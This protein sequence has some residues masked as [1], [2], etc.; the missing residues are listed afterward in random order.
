M[1][2]FGKQ[3][4]EI[5]DE[6]LMSLVAKKDKRAFEV[7]Y[8]RYSRSMVNYFYRMLWQ[9]EEKAQDFMQ[10]LFMK[11]VNKPH[12]Y[13]SK[14]AFKTWLYSI[15]NNMCKNEYRKQEIRKVTSYEVKGDVQ[16]SSD[17]HTIR[18]ID[19]A[20][21]LEELEEALQDMDE[22]RR[23]TF[24]MRFR[25]DMS[26]KEISDALECSEGTVKSRLFY[27][28]KKLNARLKHFEELGLALSILLMMY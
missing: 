5:A 13:D 28:L 7:L 12:L 8:E 4:D 24:V 19:H 26:I 1:P 18:S 23:S 20:A 14:R 17:A 21:F 6:Q 3:Y 2:L 10:E 11:L 25:Q 22:V 15:A 9:D 27:T 16:G